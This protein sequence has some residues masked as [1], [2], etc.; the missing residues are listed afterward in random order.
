MSLI[1]AMKTGAYKTVY[2][3]AF[4]LIEVM[5]AVAVFTISSVGLY[6]VNQQSILLANRLENKTLA[7][8]V[9]LNAYN[10]LDLE[11]ELP[12]AGLVTEKESMA[13]IEWQVTIN[14]TETPVASVRRVLITVSDESNQDYAKID[15]FIGS[16]TPAQSKGL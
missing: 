14:I 10:R 9:A 11:T 4:T 15:A 1:F 7:H 6:T 16:R 8:W 3:K 5:A 2:Q 13:G 12:S